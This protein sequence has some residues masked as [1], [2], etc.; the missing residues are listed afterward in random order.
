MPR[1]LTVFLLGAL[2]A[3]RRHRVP[4]LSSLLPAC[5]PEV[6][7]TPLRLQ[8]QQQVRQKPIL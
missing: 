3:L 8:E 1:N 5:P 6:P 2:P 7:E 4:Q